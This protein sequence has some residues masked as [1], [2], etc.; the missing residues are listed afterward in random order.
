[1]HIV[2]GRVVVEVPASWSVARIT[3]GPGSRRVRVT[4]P[5]DPH[6]ALHI[7]QSF[8]PAGTLADTAESLRR[9][10]GAQ[11]PGVFVDV[12]PEDQVAGRRAVTYREVRPGRVIRWSVML[13]GSTRISVG[14]ESR[15][16]AEAGIRAACE[17]AVRSA[18]ELRKTGA[19]GNGS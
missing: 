6:L 8:A 4:A 11:P 12:R 19:Q 2:E 7:T 14:C 18:R 15:P 5:D 3:G 10:I 13:D 9:A 16:G 17:A 1:M